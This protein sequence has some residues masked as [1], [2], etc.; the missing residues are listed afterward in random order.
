MLALGWLLGGTVGLGTVAYA[1]AIG[2]LAQFFIPL[3]A[4]PDGTARGTSAARRRRARH[5]RAG[6]SRP[7]EPSPTV[8]EPV[9]AVVPRE[10]DGRVGVP[11]RDARRHHL[12]MGENGWRWTDA[13]IFV[14]LVIAQRRRTAPPGGEIPPAGG[15]PPH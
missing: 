1:L 3:F 6:H 13:W 11:F 10:P 14:S 15:R 4:V 5:H 9:R 7:A 12:C 2:P 8:R